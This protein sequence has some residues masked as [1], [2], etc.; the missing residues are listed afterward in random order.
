MEELFF[1]IYDKRCNPEDYKVA[2]RE[3]AD[4]NSKQKEKDLRE[5][6]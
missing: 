5:N 4:T 6:D 2:V 3:S 1:D